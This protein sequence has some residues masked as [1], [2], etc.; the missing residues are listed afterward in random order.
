MRKRALPVLAVIVALVAAGTAGAVIT[1]DSTDREPATQNA[2]AATSDAADRPIT[3]S[4]EGSASATP[5]EAVVTVAVVAEGA[6]TQAIRDD[7]AEGASDLRSALDDANV[8]D[9]QLSTADYHIREPHRRPDADGPTY[10]GVHAF[11]VRLDDTDAVGGVVDAAADSGAEV[12]D[13]RFTLSDDTR[14]AL[15]DEALEN[16]MD[17]ARGQADTLAG[18]GDLRVTGV[19][20]IDATDRSYSPVRY[21]AEAAAVASDSGTTIET[22]DAS[23]SVDV[24]VVY[25]ATDA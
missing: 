2:D 17:D 16:A 4:G 13:V 12:T 19:A 25:N 11:E 21:E 24:R 5:D 20:S 6:D 22:G 15:R 3:V 1:V 14:T 7:L 23:V 8:A 18:A 9:E 10:R